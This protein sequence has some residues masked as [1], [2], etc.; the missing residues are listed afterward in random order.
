MVYHK[1]VS[2]VKSF[3]SRTSGETDAEIPCLSLHLN[4]KVSRCLVL[5]MR[6]LPDLYACTG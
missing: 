2:D 1:T 5:F 4:L 6:N 3:L